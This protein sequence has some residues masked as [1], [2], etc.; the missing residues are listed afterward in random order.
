MIALID[1]LILHHPCLPYRLRLRLY[2]LHHRLRL[3]LLYLL[4]LHRLRPHPPPARPQI[5]RKNVRLW[6]TNK[7]LATGVLFVEV[8][9]LLDY[10][11]N[12]EQITNELA[13]EDEATVPYDCLRALNL[14]RLSLAAIM[15]FHGHRL[16]AGKQKMLNAGGG[17]AGGDGGESG[18]GRNF[19]ATTTGDYYSFG[20]MFTFTADCLVIELYL[21]TCQ[22]YHFNLSMV[23]LVSLVAYFYYKFARF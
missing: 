3:R 14:V 1:L 13:L 5:K 17:A 6:Y 9:G 4:R 19:E 23:L 22:F 15:Y 12:R 10:H 20:S 18:G 7:F 16:L 11:G 2:L 21:Y 8:R